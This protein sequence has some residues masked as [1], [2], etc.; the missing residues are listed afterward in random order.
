[1]TKRQARVRSQRSHIRVYT[2]DIRLC[3]SFGKW[4]Q[5]MFWS[6]L[7]RI[8]SPNRSITVQVVNMKV[9]IRIL[10]NEDLVHQAP[11]DT[12][13]GS[14]KWQNNIA[15][16]TA[17][18]LSMSVTTSIFTVTYVLI[19]PDV[20]GYLTCYRAFIQPI[21]TSDLHTKSFATNCIQVL[22]RNK[23]VVGELLV[24]LTSFFQLLSEFILRVRVESKDV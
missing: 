20:G 12:A 14:R 18:Y 7:G 3:N 8:I 13:D 16:C 15:S 2:L 17:L 19:T 6:P 5:P 11:I 4:C 23:L 21:D 10:R 24:R 9:Y 22:Q 1:V